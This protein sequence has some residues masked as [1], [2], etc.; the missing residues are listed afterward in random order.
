MKLDY[1]TPY[2]RTVT[3]K[4]VNGVMERTFVLIP[5]KAK[6]KPVRVKPTEKKP[7]VSLGTCKSFPK[8]EVFDRD[9][10]GNIIPYA[11]WSEIALEVLA[12]HRRIKQDYNEATT[13]TITLSNRFKKKIRHKLEF[14]DRSIKPLTSQQRAGLIAKHR[15]VKNTIKNAKKK[16]N[17]RNYPMKPF[18]AKLFNKETY[19]FA[20]AKRWI[21]SNKLETAHESRIQTILRCKKIKA[22]VD[23]I[24]EE[25]GRNGI[26]SIIFKT[27]PVKD[28]KEQ[29]LK[30]TR[31]LAK[32]AAGARL[33]LSMSSTYIHNFNRRAAA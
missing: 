3:Y 30:I 26:K 11:M 23:I 8:Q 14:P 6:E 4:E 16:E 29:L 7:Y 31:K 17:A 27:I 18:E 33:N 32:T 20:R 15:F 25:P 5:V 24:N 28:T 19:A 12:E 9:E 2:M 21:K 22:S 10:H 1:K 13:E